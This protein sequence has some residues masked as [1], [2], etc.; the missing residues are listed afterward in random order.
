MES[1][2]KIDDRRYTEQNNHV[3][4][5]LQNKRNFFGVYIYILSEQRRKRAEPA[6]RESCTR[7][8]TRPA[9]LARLTF[10]SVRPK[11][12]KIRLFCRLCLPHLS[13]IY[14]KTT[15]CPH[16][17]PHDTHSLCYDKMNELKPVTDSVCSVHVYNDLNGCS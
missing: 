1:A 3:Y 10:V 13:A 12:A 16:F 6:R 11:Y 8:R 5:S 14:K 4:A 9:P 17:V 2:Y 7:G 15:S